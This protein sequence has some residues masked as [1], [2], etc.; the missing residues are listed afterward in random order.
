MIVLVLEE[1][2]GNNNAKSIIDREF[3]GLV[4]QFSGAR[5]RVEGNTDNTGSDSVNKPLSRKRAQA[6]VDYLISEC[7]ASPSQFTV[8]GNGSKHAI[9]AGS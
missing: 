9:E 2:G 4:K 5:F 3:K 7:G 6:V 1:K 8:V